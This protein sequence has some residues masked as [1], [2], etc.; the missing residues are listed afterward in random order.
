LWTDTSA[1]VEMMTSNTGP[2]QDRHWIIAPNDARFLSQ[3]ALN[4]VQENEPGYGR[5]SRITLLDLEVVEP[6][7]VRAEGTWLERFHG[8]IV[9]SQMLHFV[10]ADPKQA[11]ST[12]FGGA[13][14]DSVLHWNGHDHRRAVRVRRRGN[15]RRVADQARNSPRHR[16]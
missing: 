13:G 5:A 12:A 2:S 16:R 6:G 1:S 11:S 14:V 8:V 3:W 10:Q 15:N 4:R 9:T 7:V